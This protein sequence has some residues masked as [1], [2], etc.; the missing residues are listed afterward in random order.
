MT[1]GALLLRICSGS[2]TRFAIAAAVTL[3]VPI[4]YHL[5]AVVLRVPLPR[6]L[7]GW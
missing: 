7:F 3:V 2:G 5:F 6:G 1:A 4:A